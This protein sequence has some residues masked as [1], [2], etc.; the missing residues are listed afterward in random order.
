MW[1]VSVDRSYAEYFNYLKW[2]ACVVALAWLFVQRSNLV[3]CALALLFLYFLLDDSV[4]LHEWLGGLVTD[5][6]QWKP[7]LALRANDFGEL[8]VS[9][10]AGAVLASFVAL[11]YWKCGD[12]RSRRLTRQLLPWLILLV[13]FGIG[14]DMLDIQLSNLG[15]S[16]TLNATMAVIEDGG[17]MICAS[18][19][20]AIV[21]GETVSAETLPSSARAEPRSRALGAAPR[22]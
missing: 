14:I 12:D 19:L 4:S 11:T 20:T 22:P 7:A 8:S 13:F 1:N 15:A 6:M 3:Y 16:G 5:A 2:L 17:E 18:V 9:A 21:V 10:V